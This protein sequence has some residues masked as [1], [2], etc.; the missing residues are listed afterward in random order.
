MVFEKLDK[1]A[2]KLLREQMVDKGIEN[3]ASGY[4]E[5]KGKMRELILILKSEDNF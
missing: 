3:C 5:Y 2:I 1:K 4:F